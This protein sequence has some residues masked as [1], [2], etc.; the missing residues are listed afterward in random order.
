MGIES[1]LKEKSKFF[2]L[3]RYHAR[4]KVPILGKGA[5]VITQK[6]TL[7]FSRGEILN[8]S[9][10]E[11]SSPRHTDS[12]LM[13]EGKCQKRATLDCDKYNK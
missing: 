9:P 7:L 8:E 11:A 3:E 12:K 1:N 2:F 4:H 10:D 5:D 6:E 13:H